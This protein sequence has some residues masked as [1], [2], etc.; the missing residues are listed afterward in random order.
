KPRATR[1]QKPKQQE[2][3]SE[4][5]RPAR[6]KNALDPPLDPSQ[7]SPEWTP[8]GQVR[9]ARGHLLLDIAQQGCTRCTTLAQPP[10][11]VVLLRRVEVVQGR[12]LE[13]HE[14]VGEVRLLVPDPVPLQRA[15]P[16]KEQDEDH[17]DQRDGGPIEIVVVARDELAQLVDEEAEA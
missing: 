13:Q 5:T 3:N 14:G 7:A 17:I 6:P 12:V 4:P 9:P 15:P 16:E 8:P 1:P 2:G 10:N 11:Q